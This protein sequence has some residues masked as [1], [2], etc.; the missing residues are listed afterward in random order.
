MFKKTIQSID[1]SFEKKVLKNDE[2]IF[3]VQSSTRSFFMSK[4]NDGIWQVL[5]TNY[6]HDVLQIEP[7]LQAT[8]TENGY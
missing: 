8:L 3:L 2:F 5:Y 1:F 6:L 4:M 7:E